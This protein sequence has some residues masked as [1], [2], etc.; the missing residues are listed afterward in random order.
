MTGASIK[1]ELKDLKFVKYINSLAKLN[2]AELLANVGTRIEE[3][4]KNRIRVLKTAPNGESWVKRKDNKPH[5]LLE[6]SNHLRE[7]IHYQVKGSRVEIG[8]NLKYAAIQQYGDN[9]SITRRTKG[10]GTSKS[11]SR[12]IPSRAYLGL[13]K[14]NEIEINTIIKNFFGSLKNA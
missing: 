3:Q 10:G 8:S 2:K 6:K 14:D 1:V 12:K 7:S 13:S 11:Y 9:R 5:P 4:T